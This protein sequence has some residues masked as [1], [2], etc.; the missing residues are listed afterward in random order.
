VV[1]SVDPAKNLTQDVTTGEPSA[2][3]GGERP[4]RRRRLAD[5]VTNELRP[6]ILDRPEHA[7]PTT[8]LPGLG[9]GWD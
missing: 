7:S 6:P 2:Q 4:A 1:L 5:R 8:L 3:R 9:H